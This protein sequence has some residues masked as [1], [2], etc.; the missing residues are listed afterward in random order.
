MKTHVSKRPLRPEDF[1]KTVR[2][3]AAYFA[4]TVFALAVV[5]VGFIA[6]V[7]LAFSGDDSALTDSG[8][9]L[10]IGLV[11]YVA[12]IVVAIASMAGVGWAAN[13][14]LDRRSRVG[15]L[16]NGMDVLRNPFG[17]PKEIKRL[18]RAEARCA[19]GGDFAAIRLAFLGAE[20]GDGPASAQPPADF[21]APKEEAGAAADPQ[22][23][24]PP[25]S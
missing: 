3:F 21:G 14:W 18:R 17:M 25:P 16:Y 19:E 12:L 1:A 13:S 7:S 23:A 2:L 24:D 15:G 11:A 10:F 6:V 8:S 22:R 20:E 4:L 5:V 9:A